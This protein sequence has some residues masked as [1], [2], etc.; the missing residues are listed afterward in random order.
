MLTPKP[1]EALLL[2]HGAA[3]HTLNRCRG[4]WYDRSRNPAPQNAEVVTTRTANTLV[5]MGLADYDDPMLPSGLTL[6]KHG[7]AEAARIVAASK[8]Q[9]AAA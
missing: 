3:N 1:Q 2:A 8:S 9:Q 5:E 7:T 6:T 4:G